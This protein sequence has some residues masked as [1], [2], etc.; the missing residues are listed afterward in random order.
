[1]SRL[2]SKAQ[3][4]CWHAAP[5][6]DEQNGDGRGQARSRNQENPGKR[7]PSP[8]ISVRVPIEKRP[9][10]DHRT[11][12]HRVNQRMSNWFLSHFA[13]A[14]PAATFTSLLELTWIQHRRIGEV[15]P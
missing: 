12:G 5:A 8:A 9:P 2:S 15:R 14:A 1:M 13:G 3:G 10:E 6:E 11:S 7:H 4:R